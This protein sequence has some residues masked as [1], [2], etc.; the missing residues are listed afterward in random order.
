VFVFLFSFA[1]F[2]RY[3]DTV[4]TDAARAGVAF[5][6]WYSAWSAQMFMAPL[7]W[8]PI[9]AGLGVAGIAVLRMG[10]GRDPEFLRFRAGRVQVGLA[11]AALFV[12]FGY[13]VSQKQTG[14]GLDGFLVSRN[15][16]VQNSLTRPR[17]G[18]GGAL[19]LFG[20]VM[21]VAGALLNHFKV[22]QIRANVAAYS[23]PPPG[24]GQWTG[25]WPG[26][27]PPTGAVPPQLYPQPY[28]QPYQQPGSPA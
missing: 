6:G 17:F 28:Q 16:L 25:Q 18:W 3:P 2:V 14:F 11:L 23:T 24:P 9:L 15:D 8:W 10:T 19:M 21:G 4:V 20:A 7:S 5:D 1:P 13:A 26:R 27:Q 12:L 22:G